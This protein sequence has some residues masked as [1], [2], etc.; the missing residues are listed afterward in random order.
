LLHLLGPFLG[1]KA[2]FEFLRNENK[3]KRSEKIEAITYLERRMR[4]S[5]GRGHI[6]GKLSM[7]EL[8]VLISQTLTHHTP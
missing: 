6:I 8:N 7:R 4:G 5:I 2:H 1:F 3:V